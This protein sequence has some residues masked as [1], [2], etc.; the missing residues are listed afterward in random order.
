METT[1]QVWIYRCRCKH[2]CEDHSPNFPLRCR[3]CSC[4]DFT[5]NFACLTCDGSWEDHDV[6]YETGDERKMLGKAVG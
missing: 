1:L 5:S 3:K 2:T 4:M 6:M